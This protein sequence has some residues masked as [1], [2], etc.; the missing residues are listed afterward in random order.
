[1][2]RTLSSMY[3]DNKATNL[4]F[5]LAQNR[6]TVKLLKLLEVTD[7]SFLSCILSVSDVIKGK[8]FLCVS[9]WQT[10]KYREQT[11]LYLFRKLIV[12]HS[13]PLP[14]ICTVTSNSLTIAKTKTAQQTSIY[15][16]YDRRTW[17][18]WNLQQY[19]FISQGTRRAKMVRGGGT[20]RPFCTFPM[21]ILKNH[22]KAESNVARQQLA[23]YT[24]PICLSCKCCYYTLYIFTIETI[25]YLI[26]PSFSLRSTL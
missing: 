24:A 20:Y 6:D 5:K 4:H 15:E 3:K 21:G 23:T 1:M 11:K 12:V 22:R 26:C 9:P 7:I 14:S 2:R 16:L 17:C 8:S 18:T 19:H 13:L 10:T 25:Q